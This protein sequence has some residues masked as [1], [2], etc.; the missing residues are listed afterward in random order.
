[1]V[2]LHKG[3]FFTQCATEKIPFSGESALR[4]G[5]ANLWSSIYAATST[6]T[7]R[8]KAGRGRSIA[9]A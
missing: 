4:T 8:A 2:E 6:P 5:I 7:K 3:S 9:G 1:M